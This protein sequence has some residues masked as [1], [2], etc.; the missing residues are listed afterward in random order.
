MRITIC[1]SCGKRTQSHQHEYLGPNYTWIV[2]E[3]EASEDD[4]HGQFCSWSCLAAWAT[5]KAIEKEGSI[6]ALTK[7][8]NDGP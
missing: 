1:D 8:A 7:E 5:E 4:D 2:L 3:I 6:D